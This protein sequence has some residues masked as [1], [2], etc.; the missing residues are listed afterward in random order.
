VLHVL[1][2]V[3]MP[4]VKIERERHNRDRTPA[5]VEKRARQAVERDQRRQQR[6][7]AVSASCVHEEQEGFLL[8]AAA[9]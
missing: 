2:D 9:A 3:Q 4:W 5:E 6:I 1:G 8:E 7:A